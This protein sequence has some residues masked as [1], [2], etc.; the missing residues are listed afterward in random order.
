MS[1]EI[2]IFEP[3]VPITKSDLDQTF[4]RR[5]LLKEFISSQMREN[6]DYGII[7]G[8]NQQSLLKPGAEKLS[9]LFGLATRIVGRDKEVDLHQNF[10][11][12][13]YTIETYHIRTG[14]V[15]AQCEGSCNSHERKYRT[16]TVKGAKEET[17]VG[18]ILNTLMKMAQ[19]RAYV[20]TIIQATGASDF[21]TQD[22]DD[23]E[24]AKQLN[25]SKDV[26]RVSAS[27]PGVKSA[28]SVSE[29][30][31]PTCCNKQ[32]MVS[33]FHQDTWYCMTCKST[34]P[35]ESSEVNP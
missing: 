4:E 6:I 7:P 8:T 14:Q 11:M 35:M 26:R 22:I 29:G 17:Q 18:D 24:D 2:T 20:G 3:R 10:A 19:K 31:N 30:N 15:I 16:R 33:K 25:A 12:F 32:M 34:K 13:T 23:L 27:V 9:Q 28:Q 5:K 21:Y 1:N